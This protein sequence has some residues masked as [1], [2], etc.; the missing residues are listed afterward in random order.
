MQ[1]RLFSAFWVPVLVILLTIGIIAGIGELLLAMAEAKE[2]LSGVKEPYA[3]IVATALALLIL[4][5]ATIVARS[6]RK[7]S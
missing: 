2:E 7:A 4:I 5:G 1:E 3:V 6:G